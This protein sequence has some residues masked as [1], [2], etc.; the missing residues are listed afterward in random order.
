MGP[1][2]SKTDLMSTA[3]GKPAHLRFLLETMPE[4]KLS[5]TQSCM[6]HKCAEAGERS[7][8]DGSSC[9]VWGLVT[10]ALEAQDGATPAFPRGSLISDTV[11]SSAL[12]SGSPHST[13]ETDALKGE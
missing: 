10:G 2:T 8:L 12:S 7:L 4:G 1:E 3:L 5:F 13:Q 11:L 9:S 6:T